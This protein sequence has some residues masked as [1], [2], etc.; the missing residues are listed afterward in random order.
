MFF[1]MDT[2]DLVDSFSGHSSVISKLAIH[3]SNL[4]TVS[5]DRTMRIFNIVDQSQSESVKL[6]SEGLDVK[7]SS[8]G[9]LIAALTYDSCITLFDAKDRNEIGTIDTRLDVDASRLAGDDIKKTTSEKNKSFTCIAFSPDSLL[10]LAAGQ[11]NFFALY[12]VNDRIL[13]K[14]FFLTLNKSLDGVRLDIDYRKITEFGNMELFESSDEENE[15][16][17]GSLKRKPKLAGTTHSDMS[18]RAYKKVMKVNSVDFN[19]TCRSF[20]VVST[21]GIGLYSLDNKRRFDPFE[22]ALD[23]TP[24]AVNEALNVTNY[25]KALSLALR[26]NKIEI[27][28]KVILQIHYKSA[29]YVVSNLNIVYVEKLLKIFAEEYNNIFE[30]KFHLFHHWLNSILVVHKRNL[31]MATGT[32]KQQTIASLTSIQQI[33]NNQNQQVF[34]PMTESKNMID[35][36]LATRNLRKLELLGESEEESEE[37]KEME[38]I[39]ILSD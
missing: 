29:K 14:K 6:V 31:K 35:Y 39:E 11:S 3:G 26:L 24:K 13:L 28:K 16:F 7:F 5:L 2:G 33:I 15:H 8:C 27:I 23:V 22:F 19:P 1:S 18:E 34:N 36:L 37:E 9:K 21:E 12:S 20:A 17:Y 10:L 25:V 30:K 4:A 32:S 38:V